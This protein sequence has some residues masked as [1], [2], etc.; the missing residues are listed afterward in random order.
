M[1]RIL[2][3]FGDSHTAGAEIEEPYAGKC[4]HRAYPSYIAKHYGF[5]YENFAVSGGS[6][7]WMLRQFMIRIQHAI[8]KNQEVF[9]LCN[10]C[11]PAR[12]YVKLPGKINHCCPSLLMQ[13][14]HTDKRLLVDVDFIKPYEDYIRS[15]TDD[16]LNHKALSQILTIQSICDQYSIPYV[17]HISTNWYEGNWNLINKNNFFGHHSTKK[18]VYKESDIIKL[19]LYQKYTFWG[20]ASCNSEWKHIQ[21]DPR[22]AKHYP[23]SFHEFWANYLINFIDEQKI[24]DTTTESE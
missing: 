22:W 24:L 6:N 13:N 23:E 11:D 7:D 10:F 20:Y 8:I 16:F 21:N 14:E 18:L 19:E 1:K 17:F 3:A 9:V 4:Y 15:N 12:T 2:L 5:D